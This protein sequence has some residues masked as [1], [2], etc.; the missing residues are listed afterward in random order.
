MIGDTIIMHPNN[1]SKHLLAKQSKIKKIWKISTPRYKYPRQ[2]IN[3][4]I[5]SIDTNEKKNPA[6]AVAP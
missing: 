6:P 5:I 3:I 1:V 4:Q 2:N